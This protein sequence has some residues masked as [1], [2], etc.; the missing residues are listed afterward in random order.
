VQDSKGIVVPS[1]RYGKYAVRSRLGAGGMAEVFL[2]EAIDERGDQINVAL[3]LMNKGVS[4]EAFADEADLMGML[5]HPN[6]VQRLEVG[7]AFGRPYIA[8]EFLIGGDL[9]AVMDTHRRQM[10]EFPIAIGVHVV[11][12]VLRALAYFHQAKTRSGVSLGLVHSDVNPSNVFFS[13]LGE[14]KLGDFGVAKSRRTNVGPGDGVTAGKLH[15]LSPEQTR[16]EPLVPPSDLFSV[17]VMLHE[18]VVGYHPF[19]VKDGTPQAV[20]AAI[21]AAK[22]TLPDY[23]DKPMAQI[24]QRALHPDLRSRYRSAGEFAGDLF[25]YTLD[26]NLCRTQKEMQHWL[27]SVLGLLV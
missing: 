10:S 24:L 20:M 19:Q 25:H 17:G 22:L 18:I 1:R 21:R 23:V 14:V 6:L 8:M 7:E 3:K 5:S 26:A 4:E 13:G 27:E 12:E 2:A 15:Y 9:R 16:G 11:I